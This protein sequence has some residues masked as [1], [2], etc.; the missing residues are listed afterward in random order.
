MIRITPRI[1]SFLPFTLFRHILQISSKSV[2]KFLSYLVHKQMHK[3]THKQTQTLV[4]VTKLMIR[5]QSSGQFKKK[6]VEL[7]HPCNFGGGGG[8]ISEWV[9]TFLGGNFSVHHLARM[10]QSKQAYNKF[11][12]LSVMTVPYITLSIPV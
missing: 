1:E 8:D 11:Y 6:R 5:Q 10:G 12:H 7:F 9:G 2:C 4:E 3:Q